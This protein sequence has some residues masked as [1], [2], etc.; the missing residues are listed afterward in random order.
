[1]WVENKPNSLLRLIRNAWHLY[2]AFFLQTRSFLPCV[3]HHAQQL[4]SVFTIKRLASGGG[5]MTRKIFISRAVA[6]FE[7]L[8]RP[9][10]PM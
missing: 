3:T 4:S 8:Q 2:H 1:M 10:E 9:E 7:F 6:A 5:H